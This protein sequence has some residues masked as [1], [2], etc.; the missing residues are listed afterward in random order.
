MC[1]GNNPGEQQFA[2]W[3]RKMAKGLLNDADDNIIIPDFLLCPSNTLS[4]LIDYTYPDISTSHDMDYFHERC[5]LVPRNQETNKINNFI[6]DNFP[7]T[8]YHLWAVDEALDPDTGSPAQQ[9]YPS[10]VLHTTTPSGFPQAHLRL[11]IGCP[12]IV[13][14][15]LHSD[16]ALCKG[17]RGIVT[18][19]STRVIEVLL[20]TGD[21][22]MIPHVKL[23]ST[24]SQLPFHLQRHQ[25]PLVLSFTI[26]INKAQGQSFTTVG[27]D[28]QVPAFAHGQVYVT[29]LCGWSYKKV[30]C[31]LNEETT[32]CMKM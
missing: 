1:V 17:T 24:D 31:L 9:T 4:T 13:L 10:E 19:I 12:V 20:H 6:L 16:E 8:A 29:F 21:T 15:N 11:K 5:I 2:Q 22:C 27:I 28:L 18:Q 14:R 23:I 30:K 32:P 26:T 7:G 25:F 3:L